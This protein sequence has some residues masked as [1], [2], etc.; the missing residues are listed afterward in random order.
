MV[1]TDEKKYQIQNLIRDFEEAEAV[2]EHLAEVLAKPDLCDEDRRK[3]RES[4]KAA[5]ERMEKYRSQINSSQA[6]LRAMDREYKDNYFSAAQNPNSSI[7]RAR[8]ENQSDINEIQR[9]SAQLGRVAK[10]SAPEKK[11]PLWLRKDKDR[12]RGR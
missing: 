9:G 10:Q 5:H 8:R 7:D 11:L 1:T 6:A 12:D 2:Y 4:Q 3:W